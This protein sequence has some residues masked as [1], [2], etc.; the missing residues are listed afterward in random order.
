MTARTKRTVEKQRA[1]FLEKLA[2]LGNVTRAM[3]A[4]KIARRT[5]YDWR[6]ADQEF[7]VAWERALDES[8]GVLEDE[9]NRRALHGVDRPVYQG[10]KKVGTIREYSDTLL[11]FLLKGLRPGKYRERYEHTGEGG[12]PLVM[13]VRRFGRQPAGK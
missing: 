6:Q 1:A 7:A 13:E 8:A 11:I 4:A 2:E 9:A 12:G 5:L 10:G 3:K